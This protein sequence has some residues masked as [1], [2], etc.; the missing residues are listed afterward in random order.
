MPFTFKLLKAQKNVAT[1]P[2]TLYS[3]GADPTVSSAIVSNCRFYNATGASTTVD[4]KVTKGATTTTFAK[5]TVPASGSAVFGSEVT[6]G[7]TEKLEASGSITL[8][9]VACG[10]ERRP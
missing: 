6:L 8:D 5:L 2:V 9:V 7:P 10:V 4:L 1:W 3:V